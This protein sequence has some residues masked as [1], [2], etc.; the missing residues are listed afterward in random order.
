[1]I[2]GWVARHWR[3]LAVTARGSGTV[4]RT[5]QEVSGDLHAGMKVFVDPD[6]WPGDPQPAL[7]VGY[8]NVTVA[9]L[10]G[11][12]PAWQV[13]GTGTTWVLFVHGVDGTRSG[14]L[15]PL[16]TVHRFGLPM[17]MITYRGDQGA[18]KSCTTS[19]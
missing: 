2:M 7:D 10:Q 15:R 1:M 17:L 4:S 19:A 6:V 9:G 5:L 8:S 16:T 12:L 13:A 11:A 18:P 14:G 3:S